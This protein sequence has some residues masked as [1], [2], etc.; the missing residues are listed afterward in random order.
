METVQEY[1]LEFMHIATPFATVDLATSPSWSESWSHCKQH[2]YQS[3]M[4]I[5]TL[6]LDLRQWLLSSH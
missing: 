1:W 6:K 3:V 4:G 5:L 2:K